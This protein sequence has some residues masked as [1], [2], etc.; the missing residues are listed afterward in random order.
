[1]SK[2][3]RHQ[4]AAEQQTRAQVIR[5][6]VIAQAIALSFAAVPIAYAQ[7]SA[8]AQQLDTIT[9][10]GIR[11][12]IEAAISIKQN[13]NSIVEAIS[14]EDIG[15]LP[16]STV[17]ESISRL[18]GVTAQRD[19]TTGRA[20]NI[21]IR[22]FSGDFAGG[23]L[24]G[25]EQASTGD[26]RG[27]ELD[28]FPS[29]LLGSIV[30]YKT[31]DAQLVGQGLSGTVDQ[32]TLRPLDFG[33]RQVGVSYKNISSGRG[34]EETDSG[35]GSRLALTYVDQFAQ[36]TLGVAAGITRYKDR[37][38][39]QQKF[40]AWGGWAADVDF[41]SATDPKRKVKVPGGFTADTENNDY[42]RD[43]AMLALQFKPN[44]N[45][46]T[47]L[48][49]FY[50]KGS[51]STK[52]TGLEGGIGAISSGPYDPKDPSS[53]YP[54]NVL[55][56]VTLT[57]DGQYAASGTLNNYKGVVRNHIE[58]GDDKL[59]SVGWNTKFKIADWTTAADLS[60][61]KVTKVSSR[62]ETTAGLPG[63][64]PALDTISWTGF[65]GSNFTD[66]LYKTGLNYSDRSVIKLTDVNGWSGNNDL[67]TEAARRAS[68]NASPQAGYLSQ[69]NVS[70]A[71]NQI[72][73]SA[74]RDISFWDFSKID[75]GFNVT[76]RKKTKTTLEGRLV[77]KGGNPFGTAEVPG[78]G[79]AIAGTTGLPIVSWDPRGSLGTIYDVVAKVD[80]DILNKD[81][82]VK[83]KVSS[84]YAMG[85]LNGK[86][87]SIEY[88]GNV[89]IQVQNT[90][91]SSTGFNVNKQ[92]CSGNTTATCPSVVATGGTS[93]TDVLPSLNLAFDVAPEQVVR[94]GLGKVI[95]RPNMG[96][97]RAST[98]FSYN[99]TLIGPTGTS[100]TYTGDAGN[101]TL[102]PFKATA[103]D[104]SYEKYFGKKGYVSVAGFVKNL[105]SYI[106]KVARPYDYTALIS[107]A[108]QG[109]TTGLLTTP[110][111]GTGGRVSGVEL[112]VNVPF[113]LFAPALDGFGVL[114]SHSNTASKLDLTTAGFSTQDVGSATI[115]LPGLS[116][117][118][119]NA[120]IYYEN[121]GFQFG[122]AVRDRSSFL[123]EVKDFQDNNQYTFIDAEAVVDVQAGYEF[124]SGP[125]KGLGITFTGQ[126]MTK[127]K[128]RRFNDDPSN[129]TESTRLGKT[130]TFGVSYKF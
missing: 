72:R 126:N 63:N 86:V 22:G 25:R 128:F 59:L 67:D 93:Y 69:P 8:P 3:N 110:I 68:S 29:E 107:G 6:T 51:T 43:G 39:G 31:P 65:N 97:M 1:L 10:T 100:G 79:S 19:R 113:S 105:D 24:N 23:L 91:Q 56:G 66:V 92:S 98:G 58:S 49:V 106:L 99:A 80:P 62:Y 17:A 77:I 48:D 117:R 41:P 34:I 108:P 111:N 55:S 21:S 96:D 122:V 4:A 70:D 85:E 35:K 57:A 12:G 14:A 26:S 125:I 33:K 47:S 61:S 95:A 2:Q 120:K 75:F 71:I 102:K 27:L 28:Q 64:A 15:K 78:S 9:V 103:F 129:P 60:R 89:G 54:A 53:I 123:G 11:R 74:G 124:Q 36:R 5:Y 104:L 127:A 37:G 38:A 45:F 115:P 73:L 90:K 114:F 20:K 30:L 94:V 116:R 50:S 82:T 121:Y 81:W 118:V 109:S 18:P 76:D 7:Q 83:E 32:R 84:L 101:P 112:S 88:R 130:F 13:S 44:K 119:T 16:D 87:G 42:D 52:K 40:N 46:E